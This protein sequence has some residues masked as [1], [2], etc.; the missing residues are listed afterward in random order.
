MAVTRPGYASLTDAKV[1]NFFC[2]K[3]RR[4]AVLDQRSC[5]DNGPIN[6]WKELWQ[7][8]KNLDNYFPTV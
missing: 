2:K 7:D 8:D 3:N 4:I 1:L 6:E 5:G